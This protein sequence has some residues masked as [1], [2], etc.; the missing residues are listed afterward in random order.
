MR[1]ADG[2]LRQ[3]TNL[4][5]G[6]SGITETSPAFSVAQRS[7]RLVYSVFRTNGY[8]LYAVDSTRR[9]SPAGRPS[10]PAEPVA[11]RLPPAARASAMLAKRPERSRHGPAWRHDVRDAARTGPGSPSP[12]WDSP[13]WS[14]GSSEFGTY[15]GGGA[16]PLLQ[17][18]AGESQPH[19]RSPGERW[20][21]GHHR[22]RGLPEHGRIGS[23]GARVMQQ[24][25]Y[26]TGRFAAGVTEVN[27]EPLYVEQQLLQRQTNRDL[28]GFVVLSLQHRAAASSSRPA[29][30]T[31]PSTTSSRRRASPPLTGEQVVDTQGGSARRRG[32]QPRRRQRGAGV[33]QLALRRHRADPGAALPAAGKS[34]H[35]LAVVRGRAGRLPAVLPCPPA[36]SHW[37]PRL[38][39]YG[40][41]GAGQRGPPAAAAVSGLAGPGARLS[42]T[43]PSDASECHPTASDPNGC[44]VFDQL[45]GS[46]MVVGNLELRFPLFGALGVGSGYYG[47]FPVDFTLFGDGG[48]G[49][50]Q[51]RRAQASRAASASRGLQRRRRPARS[52]C[53]A[54]PSLS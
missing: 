44:P 12:P 32:P 29:S 48:P 30:A 22:H 10:P 27:G 53:S 31:S 9:S 40:R 25:P 6:V 3:V 26:L 21:Q 46:R 14:P 2:E 17:R 47:V 20:A 36:R 15:V 13:R 11:A 35:R 7:G 16:V 41:Y 49:L 33:R 43:A 18:R 45:L 52:T 37:R 8:E 42:G 5:T 34:D 1:L 4:F 28:Q 54:S 23:T 19:H 24:V 51:Q 50:G 38:L 39:H